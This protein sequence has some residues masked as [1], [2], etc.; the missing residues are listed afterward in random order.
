MRGSNV[1][2]LVKNVS[3]T[4]LDSKAFILLHAMQLRCSAGS[5][6]PHC[7][8]CVMGQILGRL[9]FGLVHNCMWTLGLRLNKGGG[10]GLISNIE[11]KGGPIRGN[12]GC[13]FYRCCSIS[14][15]SHYLCCET[16]HVWVSLWRDHTG[17][18]PSIYIRATQS[19]RC[20]FPRD[21]VLN[22]WTYPSQMMKLSQNMTYDIHFQPFEELKFQNF[23]GK[24]APRCP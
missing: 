10:G 16:S 3:Q 24:H 17:G 22:L 19:I 11:H 13:M 18:T 8:H 6:I 21:F 1:Q 5:Q 7:L 9:A 12:T 23:P 15:D 4:P 20:F 2:S 14:S